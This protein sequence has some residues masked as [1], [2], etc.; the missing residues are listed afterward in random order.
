LNTKALGLIP[1]FVLFAGL[2]VFVSYFYPEQIRPP[3]FAF[4]LPSPLSSAY[5]LLLSASA[6]AVAYFFG[7]GFLR[8]R[9]VGLLVLGGGSLILGLGYPLSQVLGNQPFGG[10]NQ[11][12]GVGRI[13]FLMAGLFYATFAAISLSGRAVS[14]GRPKT[15][16]ALEYG[17]AVGL[18]LATA[19]VLETS[20]A[21]SFF[22]AGSGPTLLASQVFDLTLVLFAA[23]SIILMK[24]YLTARSK[25]IYWFTL[26]I[27]S[28]SV[29]VLAGLL[30][31]VP[32]GLFAWQGR[33][34]VAIG[35][36]YFILAIIEAFKIEK[37]PLS[38]STT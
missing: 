17:A 35:G 32:G 12:I 24:S 11:L 28:L 37:R 21:P 26:G 33:F 29:A 15:W 19:I 4:E 30:G 2:A 18:I 31:R 5:S 10:P 23:T 36:V 20:L 27:A 6:L 9:S 34:S 7:R 13:S 22:K 14:S 3:V 1:L 16:L 8:E 38:S 25:I